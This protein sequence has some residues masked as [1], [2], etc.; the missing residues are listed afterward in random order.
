[1]AR[2]ICA[3]DT[4]TGD[5]ARLCCP[6]C[7]GCW[8]TETLIKWK[9]LLWG[10]EYFVLG[11]LVQKIYTTSST[12]TKE[13]PL[14]YVLPESPFASVSTVSKGHPSLVCKQRQTLPMNGCFCSLHNPCFTHICKPF[15]ESRNWFTAWRNLFLGSLNVYKYELRAQINY[16]KSTEGFMHLCSA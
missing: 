11:F 9:S 15:K 10:K 14:S 3:G 16:K 5:P 7:P 8:A 13:G 6:L 12:K 4:E 1:M 2:R